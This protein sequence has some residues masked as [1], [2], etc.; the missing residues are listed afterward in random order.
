M[1]IGCGSYQPIAAYI[2]S[3]HSA[4]PIYASPS[5]QLHQIF[6]FT[7]KMSGNKAGEEKAYERELGGT[8]TRIW[9]SVLGGP[10]RHMEHVTSVGPKGQ[11]GGE[12]VIEAGR[13][14][15]AFSLRP[16]GEPAG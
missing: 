1:I 8:V 15:L 14:G 4:Y 16:V 5:L 11:N 6:G 3:T 13:S 2:A 9:S 10:A 7:S 12:I